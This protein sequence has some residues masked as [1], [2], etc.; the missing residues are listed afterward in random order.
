MSQNTWLTMKLESM[1]L[2]L[3]SLESYTLI[4]M[5]LTLLQPHRNQSRTPNLEGHGAECGGLL[6]WFMTRF[7]SRG[8]Q[9]LKVMVENAVAFYR[10]L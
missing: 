5:L 4:V 7:E 2:F 1:H 3:L 8:A 9:T 6:S 10:S